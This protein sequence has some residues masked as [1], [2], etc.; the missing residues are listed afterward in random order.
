MV[1]AHSLLYAVYVCLIVS[2][3]CG[4]LLYYSNLYNMLNQFYNSREELYLQNQ[5]ALNYALSNGNI[6]DGLTDPGTGITT[7]FELKTH[8]LLN[9]IV[10]K[11]CLKNDTIT[12][13][14]IIGH[15]TAWETALFVTNLSN[16]L[17]YSGNVKLIGSKMLPNL[18]IEEKNISS[19]PNTLISSGTIKLSGTKLPEINPDFQKVF[20]NNVQQ[21][22][23][24]N[25][26]EKNSDA[27][28]FNS[29]L[30]KTTQVQL[31]SPTLQDISIKG[32]FVL[33][34]KDSI[35][36]S[37]N[38]VL[39]DVILKA[40]IIRIKKGFKGSIQ[41]FAQEKIVVEDNVTLSYPSVL[42]I[43]NSESK[44]EIIINENSKI[45]G[46]VV[47]F[48]TSF[49]KIE[50]NKIIVKAKS[51]ITGD[52]YCTGSLML[53]GSVYGSVYTN[54]FFNRTATGAYEDCIVN[55]EIDITKKPDYFI[56]IPLFKT[57]D[58]SYGVF[59]K[60]L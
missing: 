19:L 1:K 47:L 45:Y 60:V 41:A 29:F 20:E 42:S 34:E 35:V 22:V 33:Y 52:V 53:N 28:Y 57:K 46:G 13:A 43:Y 38:N 31:S 37:E 18:F 23:G 17:S 9:L 15:H 5:S 2:I 21:K 10:V 58:E 36:V 54:K 49:F 6:E 27:V 48:G 24:L 30:N 59:K 40:P 12:S 26:L 16:S 51:L 32:N 11:S 4:A 8:G 7:G 3:I 44:S 14:H 25:D 55:A 50:E 56:S 39:E